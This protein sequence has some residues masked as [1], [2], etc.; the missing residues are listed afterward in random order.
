M[1][2][3]FINTK[4]EA[5]IALEIAHDYGFTS[6]TIDRL[7]K[8]YSN[9]VFS[10]WSNDSDARQAQEDIFDAIKARRA[11]KAANRLS[12]DP[13]QVARAEQEQREQAAHDISAR[14]GESYNALL[15]RL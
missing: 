6:L 13:K 5:K 8:Q 9:N 11:E 1:P 4:P 10:A 3:L 2:S 7:Y 12:R 14:T 15:K